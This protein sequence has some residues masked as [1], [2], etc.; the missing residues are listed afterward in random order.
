MYMHTNIYINIIQ[1]TYN[2]V[3]CGLARCFTI[4]CK[5]LSV[6]KYNST[7]S[8]QFRH[9]GGRQE[10]HADIQYL[11]ASQINSASDRKTC[12][13]I[14]SEDDTISGL[15]GNIEKTTKYTLN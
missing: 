7:P 11:I 14:V 9:I 12:N 6:D 5:K 10:I 8:Y 3:G 1:N 13:S 4:K 2:I 15:R